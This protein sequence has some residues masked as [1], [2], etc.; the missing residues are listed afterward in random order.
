M[1]RT[2]FIADQHFGHKNIIQYENRPFESV[3]AM[4]SHMIE[5]WNSVVEEQ[6]KVFVAGD[7]SFYSKK[8]SEE[9]CRKLRGRKFLITGNHDTEKL[10]FYT[11]IGFEWAYDHPIILDNFWIVSHEPMYIN[12][13]MPYANIFGHVHGNPEY[14]DY[15]KQ[16]ICV[17]VER[18]EYRPIEF[19]E[20]KRKI[21]GE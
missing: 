3:V 5:Q 13:N 14:S 16:S 11:D 20:I 1:D 21:G 12:T 10:Q 15:S 4:D 17:S 19:A 9:I 8:K 7:F 2:F 18:I 6:D